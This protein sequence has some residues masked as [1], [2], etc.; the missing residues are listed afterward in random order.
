MQDAVPR[1]DGRTVVGSVFLHKLGGRTIQTGVL[2]GTNA[3]ANGA[4]CALQAGAVRGGQDLDGFGLF[5][6]RAHLAFRQ[7]GHVRVG[8]LRGHAARREKLDD[9]GAFLE[10]RADGFEHF[11]LGI[12]LEA[13]PPSMSAG[14]ADAFARGEDPGSGQDPLVDQIADFDIGV[15]A[16]SAA[17]QSC[18]SIAQR[19]LRERSGHGAGGYRGAF[20]QPRFHMDVAIDE[21]GHDELTP[22]IHYSVG[23]GHLFFRV[24]RY[25]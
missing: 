5:N 12:T 22:A 23:G 10:L 21:P 20:L 14:D 8:P 24:F 3:G 15:V 17:S 16:I 7:L 25:G 11:S 19:F 4:L 13:H 2:D 9:V 1:D 6:S 18:D